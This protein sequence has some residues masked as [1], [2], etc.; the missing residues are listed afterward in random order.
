MMHGYYGVCCKRSLSCYRY[1]K[2]MQIYG[3][4]NHLKN[5]KKQFNG[6]LKLYVE[7]SSCSDARTGV[8]LSY[9]IKMEI[10]I[11]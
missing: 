6:K 7:R 3:T 1:G 2:I 4:R 10:K 5:K 8:Y 9:L 11:F